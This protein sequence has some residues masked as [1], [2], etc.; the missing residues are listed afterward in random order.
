MNITAHAIATEPTTHDAA[1]RCFGEQL[2]MRRAHTIADRQTRRRRLIATIGSALAVAGLTAGSAA[3]PAPVAAPAVVEAGPISFSMAVRPG[4][5]VIMKMVTEKS[6]GEYAGKGA[7]GQ[8]IDV[9]LIDSGVTPVVGLNQPGKIVYGPDLSNEGGQ[10]NLR[11]LDTYGHGTHLAGIIN[12]DDGNMVGGIAPD[13]R[14][15]SVKV[16]VVQLGRPTS[17]R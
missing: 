16:A 6:S 11:N 12:G 1:S 13:S 14:I 2:V 4:D 8:G 7:T 10:P 3:I 9:A 17:P 15:V 5:P